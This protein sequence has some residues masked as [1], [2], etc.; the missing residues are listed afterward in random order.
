MLALYVLFGKEKRHASVTGYFRKLTMD[1]LKIPPKYV[2][3][4][5]FVIPPEYWR[6]FRL[7]KSPK[8]SPTTW[9]W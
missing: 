5:G 2:S 7:T 9:D 6:E 4:F 3:G 8:F 1:N